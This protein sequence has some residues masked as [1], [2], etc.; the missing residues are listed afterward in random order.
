MQQLPEFSALIA[1][2][3]GVGGLVGVLVFLG[4]GF[5]GSRGQTRRQPE[6]PHD[7]GGSDVPLAGPSETGPEL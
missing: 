4:G 1:L 3:A 2:L 6:V 5:S 7:D